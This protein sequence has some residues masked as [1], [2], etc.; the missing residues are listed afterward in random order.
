MRNHEEWGST[1]DER[2]ARTRATA[3]CPDPT[4]SCSVPSDSRR[5]P[6]PSFRWLAQLRS[7]R[8]ANDWV[9]N[10]GRRSPQ[11][12]TPGLDELE[13]GQRFATIFRLAH[14]EPGRPRSR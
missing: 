1:A 13:V 5:P 3:C 2:A 7:R 10:L 8:T 4:W 9:D 12:L 14:F 6:R 11:E